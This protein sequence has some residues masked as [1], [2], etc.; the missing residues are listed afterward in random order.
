MCGDY[1]ML[2]YALRCDVVCM[3]KYR[4]MTDMMQYDMRMWSYFWRCFEKMDACIEHE[5]VVHEDRSE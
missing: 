1:A 5:D 3:Y 2:C 4:W